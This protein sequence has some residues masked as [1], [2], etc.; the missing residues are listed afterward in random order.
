MVYK[1]FIF[2][3]LFTLMTFLASN[4]EWNAVTNQVMYYCLCILEEGSNSL[5]LENAL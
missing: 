1:N 3:V 4:G 5:Y 2:L